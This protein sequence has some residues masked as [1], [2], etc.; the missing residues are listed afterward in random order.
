MNLY[1]YDRNI[2]IKSSMV[3]IIDNQEVSA[4]KGE[5]IF[6]RFPDLRTRASKLV[7]KC[8]RE[9]GGREGGREG[10]ITDIPLHSSD[11]T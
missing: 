8:V 6:P 7:E 4:L 5:E 1:L 10:R 3:L 2:L 9:V 11:L